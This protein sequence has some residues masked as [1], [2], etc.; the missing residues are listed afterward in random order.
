M[1]TQRKQIK[2]NKHSE[3]R[4]KR[5]EK[6]NNVYIYNN[7]NN[8]EKEQNKNKQTKSQNWAENISKSKS[9]I[10]LK[11]SLKNLNKI[12]MI[13]VMSFYNPQKKKEKSHR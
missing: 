5:I 12:I 10:F 4:K 2:A 6:L 7:N 1:S 13:E 9:V 3:K 8:K 11:S